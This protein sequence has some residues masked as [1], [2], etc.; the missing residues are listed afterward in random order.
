MMCAVK[1][2]ELFTLNGEILREGTEF[3]LPDGMT[4]TDQITLCYPDN[5]GFTDGIA[6]PTADPITNKNQTKLLT[7]HQEG[8]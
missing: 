1:V 2:G 4:L 7:P 5:Y 8:G 6:T 3:N